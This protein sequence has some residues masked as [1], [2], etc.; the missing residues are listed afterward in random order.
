MK[1]VFRGFR[2]VAVAVLVLSTTLEIS[3]FFG[4]Q[5]QNLRMA[6]GTYTWVI[7]EPIYSGTITKKS[8]IAVLVSG[9]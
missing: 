8:R 1:A 5:R 6:L 2:G 3:V 4:P 7:A 9:V